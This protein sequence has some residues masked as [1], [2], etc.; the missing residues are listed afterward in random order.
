MELWLHIRLPASLSREGG[1]MSTPKKTKHSLPGEERNAGGGMEIRTEP[2]SKRR[3]EA[4]DLSASRLA[5]RKQ[6]PLVKVS[7]KDDDPDVG[8]D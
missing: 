3:K 4:E 1:R 5:V 7:L 2:L 8:G 6:Q